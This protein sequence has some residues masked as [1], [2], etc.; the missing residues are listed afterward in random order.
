MTTEKIT[1]Q[2]IKKALSEGLSTYLP[3]GRSGC[4]RVYVCIGRCR[5][6]DESNPAVKR[7]NQRQTR[8]MRAAIAN[9]A[10][11]LGMNYRTQGYPSPHAIYIG[12]D[13]C[14]GQQLGQ[15]TAIVK[16]LKALGVPAYR[17]EVA[18]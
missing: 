6:G 9:A 11:S 7:A 3:E 10:R 13:N 18:D 5:D 12:Y 2:D 4:G 15:G 8:A 14:S 1:A 16:N 17:E